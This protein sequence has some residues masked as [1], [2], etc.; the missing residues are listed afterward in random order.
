M[1]K[2][3]LD[4]QVEIL[5]G[6]YREDKGYTISRELMNQMKIICLRL[7]IIPN[8]IIDT[9]ENHKKKG[10]NHYIKEKKNKKREIKANN[11]LYALNRLSFFED[12]FN[13][14]NKPEFNK[15]KTKMSRRH[16]WIDQNYIYIPI[17]KIETE[18]YKGEVYNLEVNKDNSYTS[19]FACIH[20]CWTPWFG[21]FGSKSGFDSIKECFQ[22]QSDHIFAIETGLSSTPD[23]NWRLS[24]LDNI[25]LVSFSD[26]HSTNPH[27]LAREACVFELPQLT[28]SSIIN[29]IKSRDPSKFTCTVEYYCEEGKYHYDGHRNCSIRFTPKQSEKYNNIC[30]V[31]H[32]PLTIGVLNRVEQLADRPEGFMPMNAIPFK[33]LIPLSEVIAGVLSTST[34]TKKT[35]EVYNKL[36]SRF[37]TEFSVLLEA[38]E[39]DLNQLVDKSISKWIIKNRNQE[40][41]F[42]PGYDGEYG[43]PIF[44]DSQKTLTELQPKQQTQKSLSDF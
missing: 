36:V 16:G 7:G 38:N 11:D 28:Y 31:C 42:N 17:R 14:L 44:D 40:I 33:R 4:Q 25:S 20:N 8:I 6:W 1:L 15:L 5:E 9:A 13:L 32:K 26:A 41:R 37:K 12:K 35:M 22:D 29:A 18:E 27:R 23:M 34:Y 24:A 2:L 21:I 10:G 39:G 43:T 3:P 30:P 19:E